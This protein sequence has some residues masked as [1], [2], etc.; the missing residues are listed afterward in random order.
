[1][2]DITKY[3]K[4]FYKLIES[5]LGN[6]KPIIFE[7][8]ESDEENNESCTN[9]ANYQFTSSWTIALNNFKTFGYTEEKENQTCGRTRKSPIVE[10]YKNG[11]K[12]I[13]YTE[14]FLY[15]GDNQNNLSDDDF[16]KNAK[17]KSVI[18]IQGKLLQV[19]RD[20]YDQDKERTID[21]YVTRYGYN[22]EIE[23]D[24]SNDDFRKKIL[25]NIYNTIKKNINIL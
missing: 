21:R 16:K 5:S 13:T 4:K 3:K 9:Y 23:F 19:L 2:V 24:F 7:Q 25:N 22:M 12:Q 11:E 10:L 8:E 14:K 1:M 20:A 18:I 17:E 15:A 6:S